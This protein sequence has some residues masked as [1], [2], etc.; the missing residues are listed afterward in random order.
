MS[1][2]PLLF[3]VPRSCWH[4]VFHVLSFFLLMTS[5]LL[6]ISRIPPFYRSLKYRFVFRSSLT[7]CMTINT[8]KRLLNLIIPNES[9]RNLHPVGI[10][11]C[12]NRN[13]ALSLFP[14]SSMFSFAVRILCITSFSISPSSIV[15][16][17]AS[18]LINLITIVFS[19]LA[20][21]GVRKSSLFSFVVSFV[22]GLLCFG[23]PPSSLGWWSSFLW[24]LQDDLI[25]VLNCD[26]I[27][28]NA[29]WWGFLTKYLFPY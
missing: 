22:S 7:L 11:P 4:I 20:F 27:L 10:A 29:I 9:Q 26:Q 16:L 5:N 28:Q 13:N 21:A 12:C 6:L 18:L 25:H 3:K 17:L 19:F 8:I 2:F 14:S 1:G 23:F 15:L 24:L